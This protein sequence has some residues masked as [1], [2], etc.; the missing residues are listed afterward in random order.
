ME[1]T[2]TVQL[3]EGDQT[4]FTNVFIHKNVRSRKNMA[5][6]DLNNRPIL[7]PSLLE[8]RSV[9]LCNPADQPNNQPT[10]T[11]DRGD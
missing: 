1:I 3:K 2:V 4:K 7:H 8:I 9:V 6:S 10:D 11:S 5:I